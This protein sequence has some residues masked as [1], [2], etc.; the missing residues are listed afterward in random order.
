M[1]PELAAAAIGATAALFGAGVAG[2]VTLKVEKRRSDASL[3]EARR[4]ELLRTCSAFTGAIA[5]IR[6]YSYRLPKDGSGNSSITEALD[7]AGDETFDE[8][9]IE[10]ERLRLLL[11]S[12]DAQ[13]AARL[14]LRHVYAVWVLARD[15]VD[16][17]KDEYPG[18]SPHK[19]LRQELTRLYREV[20][21]ETG[22]SLPDNVFED[23]TN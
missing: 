4:D 22:A 2:G 23:L 12:K 5:R 13:E 16:P 17:R 19:R 14:A 7:K 18:Q 6:S 20:R 8:A 10:C 3:R 9:R 15:G 11:E 1:V 21:A